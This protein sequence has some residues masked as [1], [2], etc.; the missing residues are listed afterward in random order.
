MNT[1]LR[2]GT[3]KKK[4]KKS[5]SVKNS[6]GRGLRSMPR[7]LKAFISI[8]RIHKEAMRSKQTHDRSVLCMDEACR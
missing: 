1:K 5:R 4:K 8:S 3:V 2:V 7:Y 6:L